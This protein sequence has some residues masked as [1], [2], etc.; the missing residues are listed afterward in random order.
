[1]AEKEYRPILFFYDGPVDEMGERGVGR[2]SRT[3]VF[4]LES[5]FRGV[6]FAPNSPVQI[7]GN[8]HVFHGLIIADRIV[9]ANG[10]VIEMPAEANAN[11][12]DELQSFYIKLGLSDAKYD[13]FGVASLTIY[14]NPEK[15]ICFLT[16][17]ARTTR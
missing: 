9:G 8:G 13:T 11:T 4:T 5:D 17:R 2:Q 10:D 14:N 1:M 3:V 12:K 7:N 15:D 16:E 6:L